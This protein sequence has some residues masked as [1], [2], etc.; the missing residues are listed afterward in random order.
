MLPTPC[1]LLSSA[2]EY[3]D[4][5]LLLL[6]KSFIHSINIY[7]TPAT[8]QVPLLCF[9]T[10]SCCLKRSSTRWMPS[11]LLHLQ[12]EAYLKLIYLQSSLKPQH[13]EF[14]SQLN[15]P[16]IFFLLSNSLS[17]VTYISPLKRK[18]GFLFLFA[19]FIHCSVPDT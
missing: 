15:F 6:R 7:L 12:S 5:R 16:Y 11:L 1:Q 18:H 9:C 13:S 19:C 8:G 14:P 17:S 4:K 10:C 2:S 3:K